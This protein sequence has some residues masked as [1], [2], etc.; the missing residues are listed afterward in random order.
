M[1]FRLIDLIKFVLFLIILKCN[2]YC[3]NCLRKQLSGDYCY[4]CGNALKNKNERYCETCQRK[5][6]IKERYCKYCGNK[7][8]ID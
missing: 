1:G 8:K 4:L 2:Q 3:P 7:P 6:G 5:V